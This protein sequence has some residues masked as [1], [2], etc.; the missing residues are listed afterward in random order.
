MIDPAVP[1][2]DRGLDHISK[3][4][5]AR[6]TVR[7]PDRKNTQVIASAERKA[8]E[9]APPFAGR[10]SNPLVVRPEM[11]LATEGRVNFN[12]IGNP[13]KL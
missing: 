13:E 8:E 1:F 11:S 3:A 6:L 4:R 2:P 10:I 9:T 12:L 7:L 5:V